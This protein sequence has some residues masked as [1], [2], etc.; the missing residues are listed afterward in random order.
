MVAISTKNTK[1]LSTSNINLVNLKA[2]LQLNLFYKLKSK[3]MDQK[4]WK[5]AQ[6]DQKESKKAQ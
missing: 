1:K 4:E 6:T 3:V 5:K 2:N